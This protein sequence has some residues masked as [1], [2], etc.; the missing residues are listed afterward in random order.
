VMLEVDWPDAVPA[1]FADLPQT[2]GLGIRQLRDT[3]RLD[4]P[5]DVR[6]DA[7]RFA[8]E[9]AAAIRKDVFPIHGLVG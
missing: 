7:R 4:I 1:G 3:V 6:R 8:Q 9:S 2:E 5:A